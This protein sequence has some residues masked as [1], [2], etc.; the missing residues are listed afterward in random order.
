MNA[1]Q[2]P[3]PLSS[4][5]QI[6]SQHAYWV[7]SSLFLPLDR[8]PTYLWTLFRAE[9]DVPK[10]PMLLT[11]RG[12]GF[13]EDAIHDYVWVGTGVRLHRRTGLEAGVWV[14]V[15]Y[16]ITPIGYVMEARFGVDGSK[17][18]VTIRSKTPVHELDR[19]L[20]EI[21]VSAQKK[22]GKKAITFADGEAKLFRVGANWWKDTW[23]YGTYDQRQNATLALRS[24]LHE[25][26]P[27]AKDPLAY[28]WNEVKVGEE[29]ADLAPMADNM[30]AQ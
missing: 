30:S 24:K 9:S 3:T 8:E 20:D 15:Q 16:D 23:S 10:V 6:L 14:I 7:D 12:T 13:L 25:T 28:D 18:P 21:I 19:A 29:W 2:Q 26:F 22:V 27:N 1:E 5:H 17:K 11:H 4:P